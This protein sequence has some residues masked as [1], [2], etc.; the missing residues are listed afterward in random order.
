MNTDISTAQEN[1]VEHHMDHYIGGRWVTS[2][3]K[4]MIDI[5]NPYTEQIISRVVSGSREDAASAVE[6]ARAAFDGWA[7][8]SV[9]E[10]VAVMR[11]VADGLRERRDELVEL[12]IDELGAP[13]RDAAGSQVDL[14]IAVWEQIGDLASEVELQSLDGNIL[15]TREPFGVVS[16]ITPWN[17]PL[18]QVVVKV[19][20]AMVMGCTVVLKA[21]EVTPLSA[22][23]LAEVIDQA[24]VPAGVFNLVTGT[25]PIV[26]EVLASHPAVDFVSFTG[27]T[28]AGVR[29]AE[30][31]ASGV[32]KVSLELGGKSA[33]IVLPDADLDNAVKETVARCFENSGQACS[34]LTRLLVPQDQLVRAE[35]IAAVEAAG[36]LVG[37][38]RD[39]S[40]VLG[41]VVSGIQRERVAGHIERAVAEGARVVVG[42]SARPAD[43][44]TGHFVTPTVISSATPDMAIAQDEVFGPV[45]TILPY[46]SVDEA[47]EIANDSQYGLSAAVWGGHDEAVAV[48]HRLRTGQV[49]VNGGGWNFRAPFGGYKKSGLGRESGLHGLEEFLET[50]ALRL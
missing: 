43:Q 2:S 28:V 37:D 46:G 35:D 18:H 47:V 30:L 24:G 34:A 38:P 7:A 33:S 13:R 45:L 50:K 32:K 14:P 21:S 41:P 22:L 16:C 17:Y 27:S 31:A 20:P 4:T 19:A 44:P 1:T 3:S 39:D 36:Y 11:K 42:G 49:I 26:G 15:T 40:T 8:L 10:R 29:V 5:E 12:T 6:A 48:A 9:A 23:V 25:G